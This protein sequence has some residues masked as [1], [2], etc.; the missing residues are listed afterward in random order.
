MKKDFFTD[1]FP[2]PSYL[3]MPALGLDISDHSVKYVELEKEGG[4]TFVRRFGEHLIPRGLIE[5][6]E[7]KNKEKLVDFLKA[8]QKELKSK[9]LITALPEEKAFLARIKL[10]AMKEEEIRGAIELQLEEHIPLSVNETIFDFNITKE[11]PDSNYIDVCLIAFPKK[12][13]EDYRD[14][15]AGAGFTPLVLEME[16]QAS[17]RTI[18][19]QDE[20]RT[21]AVVDFGQTRTSFAI[22]SKNEV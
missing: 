13:I 4:Q 11:T 22:I 3:L 6:G 20:K 7:I 10:P 12:I 8:L 19:P 5:S 21:L 9:Y 2:P 1:F 15:F 14:V 16:M 18:V 17:A